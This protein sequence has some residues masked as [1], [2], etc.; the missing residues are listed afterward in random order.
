MLSA[1]IGELV[2]GTCSTGQDALR[3]RERTTCLHD[4]RDE[5]LYL[6]YTGRRYRFELKPNLNLMIQ[7]SAQGFEA[8]EVLARIKAELARLLD[9]A[10]DRAVLWPPDS[11]AVPDGDPLFR[12]VYLAAEAA[13]SGAEHAGARSTNALGS[14]RTRLRSRS[15]AAPGSRERG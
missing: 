12:I 13:E 8:D 11:A 10:G 1:A 5:L 6:H 14:T 3:L 15:R 2:D 7:E 9:P 4:L